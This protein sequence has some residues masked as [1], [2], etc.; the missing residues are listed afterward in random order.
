MILKE[1]FGTTVLARAPFKRE[2]G[3]N[4]AFAFSANGNA[5]SF[6][7]DG[8]TLIEANDGQYIYGMAGLR[9]GA[10]GRMSVGTVEIVEA[11]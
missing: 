2:L 3:R 8:K 1:D 6:S 9:L 10:L 7:V 4:Y 11:A 5:L